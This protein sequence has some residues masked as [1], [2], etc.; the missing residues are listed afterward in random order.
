MMYSRGVLRERERWTKSR[1]VIGYPSG[2]DGS[3]SGLPTVSRKKNFPE[4][5]IIILYAPYSKMAA[6]LVV[7]LLAN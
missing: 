5:E 6:I 3:R 1:A 2:Q 4:S 7:F